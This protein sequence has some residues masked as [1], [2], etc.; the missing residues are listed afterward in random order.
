[1]T[2]MALQKNISLDATHRNG[3]QGT[4]IVEE[5]GEKYTADMKRMPILFQNLVLLSE[6]SPNLWMHH[7]MCLHKGVLR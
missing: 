7:K 3:V 2:I 5:F 6:F 1:M 4:T